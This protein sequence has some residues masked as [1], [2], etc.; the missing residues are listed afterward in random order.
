MGPYQTLDYSQLNHTKLIPYF[1][2]CDPYIRY[3]IAQ[4]LYEVLQVKMREQFFFDINI[5]NLSISR[6]LINLIV[7]C[8]KI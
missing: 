2:I 4:Q 3:A 8:N 6:I 5:Y 1:Q 7:L